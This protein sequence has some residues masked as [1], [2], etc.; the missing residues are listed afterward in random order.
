MHLE[1]DGGF[2]EVDPRSGDVCSPEGEAKS[3]NRSRGAR[4]SQSRTTN[5][6]SS[7][8]TGSFLDLVGKLRSGD[9][10]NLAKDIHGLDRLKLV[11]ETVERHG[12]LQPGLGRAEERR[13]SRSEPASCDALLATSAPRKPRKPVRQRGDDA[14][15][16]RQGRAPSGTAGGANGGVGQQ[17][18]RMVAQHRRNLAAFGISIA[19]G[20]EPTL[21]EI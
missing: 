17:R 6:S 16:G 10:D 21:A 3:R 8:R 2:D 13:R 12:R 19:R 20:R 4:Q 18:S 14:G 7:A 9:I 5:L 1:A 15:V 11:W